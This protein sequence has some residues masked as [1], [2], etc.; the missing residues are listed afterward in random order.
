MRKSN[1]IFIINDINAHFNHYRFDYNSEISKVRYTDELHLCAYFS[2]Q[3]VIKSVVF[4][5]AG[6]T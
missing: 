1:Q 4:R 2:S 5:R 6:N 3:Q